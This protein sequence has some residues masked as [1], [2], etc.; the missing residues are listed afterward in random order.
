MEDM[1]LE[2]LFGDMTKGWAGHVL[3]RWHRGDATLGQ[4]GHPAVYL[5]QDTHTHV[6][7]CVYSSCVCIRPSN[8]AVSK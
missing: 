5:S 3:G 6:R 1:L 8:T 7:V 2:I 4:K